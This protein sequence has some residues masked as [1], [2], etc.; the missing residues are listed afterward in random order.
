MDDVSYQTYLSNAW[1]LRQTITKLTTSLQDPQYGRNDKE[2]LQIAH[3]AALAALRDVHGDLQ[4]MDVEVP[5]Y[6]WAL[7]GEPKTADIGKV[8]E[9]LRE[10]AF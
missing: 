3:K 4:K 10:E 5:F 8:R 2:D 6:T 7:V 9:A 1:E